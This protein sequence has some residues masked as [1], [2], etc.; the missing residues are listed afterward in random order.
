MS[1]SCIVAKTVSRPAIQPEDRIGPECP[2]P[3]GHGPAGEYADDCNATV[4]AN[5]HCRL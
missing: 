4:S 5:T 3:R 2:N 1:R